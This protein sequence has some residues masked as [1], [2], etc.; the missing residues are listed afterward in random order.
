LSF[1]TGSQVN[2]LYAASGLAA[3][4]SAN[5]CPALA[6]ALLAKLH[7]DAAFSVVYWAAVY[8]VYAVPVIIAMW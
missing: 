7:G 8:A 2:Q 1:I 3:C 6:S 5:G 4:P